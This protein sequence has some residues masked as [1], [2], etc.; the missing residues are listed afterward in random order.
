MT[1]VGNVIFRGLGGNCALAL[2]TMESSTSQ[3]WINRYWL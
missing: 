2:Y 1:C 3:A